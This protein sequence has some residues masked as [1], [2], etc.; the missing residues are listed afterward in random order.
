LKETDLDLKVSEEEFLEEQDPVKILSKKTLKGGPSAE[1]V[2]TQIDGMGQ[3]LGES[4][5]WCEAGL[6]RIKGAKQEI[7]GIEE[8]LG[9]SRKA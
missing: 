4:R 2:K 6:D 7:Q 5:G 9:I 8:S 1:A 3:R